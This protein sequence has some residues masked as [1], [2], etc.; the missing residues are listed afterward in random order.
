MRTALLRTGYYGSVSF[1]GTDEG[2]VFAWKHDEDYGPVLPPSMDPIR[3]PAGTPEYSRWPLRELVAVSK[4]E[5]AEPWLF[6]D[7]P[8]VRIRLRQWAVRYRIVSPIGRYFDRSLSIRVMAAWDAEVRRWIV[9]DATRR[10]ELCE[11]ALASG[12]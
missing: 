8:P 1:Y 9:A 4:A 6:D 3:V 12:W 5:M 7:P 11:Y 10:D 2:Q